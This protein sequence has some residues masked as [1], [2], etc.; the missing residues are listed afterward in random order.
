[1]KI[2]TRTGDHGETG[3]LGG[4]RVTKDDARVEACGTIDE[5]NALIG[6]ARTESMPGEID[7]IL[8]RLQHE[9]FQAGAEVASVSP[10]RQGARRLGMDEVG[11]MESEMDRLED[12]LPPLRNFILPGGTR[13][14]A[15]LH[16][17][18]TVCRRAERRVVTAS[19][20]GQEPLSPVL[21]AYLNRLGDL[22]FVLARAAAIAVGKPDV[23]WRK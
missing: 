16:L 5:L 18:R 9:L 14:S 19:R 7:T 10:G 12:R 20:S 23:A 15:L 8:E 1:M 4:P 22:L 17:T 3:L 13:L 21:V 11:V 2:Y 6:L